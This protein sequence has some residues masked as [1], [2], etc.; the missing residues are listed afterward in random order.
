MIG[1]VQKFHPTIVIAKYSIFAVCMAAVMGF[2]ILKDLPAMGVIVCGA[3]ALARKDRVPPLTQTA[4]TAATPACSAPSSRAT[5]GSGPS[6][7][8]LN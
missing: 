4:S 6:A 5:L 1:A 2:A 7:R 8:A 3:L